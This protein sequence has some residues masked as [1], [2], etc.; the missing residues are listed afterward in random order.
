[1]LTASTHLTC[2]VAATD[3]GRATMKPVAAHPEQPE[4]TAL[5]VA[6]WHSH[7]PFSVLM[8][9]VRHIWDTALH[10]QVVLYYKMDR[11]FSF[12]RLFVPD[13]FLRTNFSLSLSRSSIKVAS[14]SQARQALPHTHR[15]KGLYS[16]YINVFQC[17][18]AP[19]I[20]KNLYRHML[21]WYD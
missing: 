11:A 4:Q 3:K 19:F 15:A 18:L 16:P 2:L 10:Y 12:N 13:L 14:A 9:M 8:A 17:V 6:G 7:L 21:A 5:A 20:S 1:M